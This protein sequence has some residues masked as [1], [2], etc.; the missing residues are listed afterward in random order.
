VKISLKQAFQWNWPVPVF[1]STHDIGW[2]LYCASMQFREGKIGPEGTVRLT[3]IKTKSLSG[4]QLLESNAA[5]ILETMS[6]YKKPNPWIYAAAIDF[7]KALHLHFD[8]A[9]E[10][11]VY[12]Y[13]FNLQVSTDYSM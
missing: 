3:V 7:A 9:R 2:W 10:I 8:V 5:D 1:S 6:E 4:S 13:E 12:S 11:I